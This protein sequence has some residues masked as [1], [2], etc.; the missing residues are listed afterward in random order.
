MELIPLQNIDEGT[1]LLIKAQDGETRK[2][3]MESYAEY[4]IRYLLKHYTPTFDKQRCY[5]IANT[6]V[7][8]LIEN[9]EKDKYTPKPDVKTSSYF[10][11]IIRNQASKEI[12][13]LQKNG[14]ITMPLEDTDAALEVEAISAEESK[15][16]DMET[17]LIEFIGDAFSRRLRQKCR[18]IIVMKHI[19]KMRHR[20]IAEEL[21]YTEKY[22]RNRL[23]RCMTYLRKKIKEQFGHENVS[24]NDL[25]NFLKKNK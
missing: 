23:Y 9:I 5:D 22:S 17:L 7:L 19:Q 20:D 16:E 15:K 25:L 10:T 8:T 12:K 21:G 2:I 4:G 24:R 1:I 3:A 6:C 13:L 11:R 18:E 14:E